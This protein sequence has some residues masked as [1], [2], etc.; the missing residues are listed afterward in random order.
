MPCLHLSAVPL[1]HDGA[2]STLLHFLYVLITAV[3]HGV[4]LLCK[5]RTQAAG[6]PILI[7]RASSQPNAEEPC[8]VRLI[9]SVHWRVLAVGFVGQAN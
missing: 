4:L 5:H 6:E 1:S 3:I 2:N 7:Q 9:N 8:D